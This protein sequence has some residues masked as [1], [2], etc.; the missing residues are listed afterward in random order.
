MY[1]VSLLGLNGCLSLVILSHLAFGIVP[2]LPVCLDM[3]LDISP[4]FTFDKPWFVSDLAGANL[5]S[6]YWLTGLL[7][8]SL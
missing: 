1:L 8:S 6:C 5:D 3:H 2:V 4:F 7:S